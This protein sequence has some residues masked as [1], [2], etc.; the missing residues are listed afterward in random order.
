MISP[1][2]IEEVRIKV[3]NI[4]EAELEPRGNIFCE[5]LKK[6]WDLYLHHLQDDHERL[7]LT[8]MLVWIDMRLEGIPE[9]GVRSWMFRA[10]RRVF[11]GNKARKGL[12]YEDLC[13]KFT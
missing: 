9:K 3:Q 8:E 11:Y 4:S 5:D 1:S 2:E 10:K 12:K 7:I 6:T 13:C